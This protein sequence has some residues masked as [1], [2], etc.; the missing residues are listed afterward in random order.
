VF[1]CRVF[2]VLFGWGG[3]AVLVFLVGDVIAVGLGGW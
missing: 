3:F 2:D 1:Y